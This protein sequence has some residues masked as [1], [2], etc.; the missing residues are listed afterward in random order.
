MELNK[1]IH[2]YVADDK[3]QEELN[4]WDLEIAEGKGYEQGIEQNKKEIA[5]KMLNSHVP[6]KDISK[7]TKL[8][9][10]EIKSLKEEM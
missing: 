9:S 10:K 4:K 2:E 1:W 3:M 5:K 6:I 7:Y 8:S